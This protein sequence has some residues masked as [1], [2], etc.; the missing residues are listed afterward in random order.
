MTKPHHVPDGWPTLAP[1]ITVPEPEK[2]VGFIKHVFGATGSYQN[3]YLVDYRWHCR[4]NCPDYF[5]NGHRQAASI[6]TLPEH[7]L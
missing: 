7:L 1:R 5:N 3:E 2:L 6:L 4:G